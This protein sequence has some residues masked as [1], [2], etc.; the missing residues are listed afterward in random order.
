MGQLPFTH[1]GVP[2]EAAATAAGEALPGEHYAAVRELYRENNRALVNFLLT[3]LH[4]EQEA[5]DVAQESYVKLLQLNQPGAVSFL[6]GYLFRIAANLSVDRLRKRFVRERA[7][8]TVADDLDCTEAPECEAIRREE[9]EDICAALDSLSINNRR[10]FVLHAIEGYSTPE[11]A[12]MLN[13]DERTVRKY[14]T[15]ALVQCQ[16]RMDPTP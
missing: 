4:C 10:A 12:S 8:A 7:A 6:R 16:H 13:I 14:V 5:L 9:F 1:P 3:R 15:R 2:A 11:V